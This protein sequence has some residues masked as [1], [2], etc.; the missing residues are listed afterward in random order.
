MHDFKNLSKK[1]SDI[2]GVRFDT[3]LAAYL[4][5]PSASSYA[6]DRI[7]AEYAPYEPEI[8]GE[9]DE[10]I[11]NACL[12]SLAC[13]TLENELEKTGQKK[14]F[15]EIEL[16]LARVL[17]EMELCGFS[18]DVN[19]LKALSSELDTR[20]KALESEIYSL[21]GYE[22]NLNSPKQLGAALFEKLGLPAKKKTKSGYS[23]GAEVLEGLKNEHPAVS[24]LLNYRQLAKLKSTYADGLQDCIA[25][26]GRI[27]STFNQTEAR[28]GRISSL[29]PNLQN[30]PVRTAE[31]RRLREYFNA[32]AGRVLCDADYSQ[33]ELRVLASMSGD[34]NMI[35][36]FGSG[37]DIHTV[38]A[39]QVFG[40]PQEMITPELR[41]RAK[42]VN[43]GI[44]YGIGAFSLS[45]DIGVTR[46]EA[47]KY[48]K[49]YLAA[50]PGVAAYM[51][52]AIEDAKK[53]GYVTT[54]YG[55]RRYI[56]ELSNSNG[57]M[58]AFGERVARNAPIQGTA[59]DII[60]IAMI[61]VSRSLKDEFPT[62]RLILQVHDEL[63]VECDERDAEGVCALLER[64]MES[65]ADLAVRLTAEAHFGKTWLEAKA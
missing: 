23:T 10:F 61:K 12:F 40:L 62:A 21:V 32:P 18:A 39:S 38:T 30:I 54:L 57:N 52:K 31:G 44:V 43:F 16:P 11:K 46:A 17:G 36:A 64:E 33:I 29:E 2:A 59:A 60:K 13:D 45:K 9:T 53:N 58:R 3:I 65:A 1:Y 37:T 28:T 5:N 26:D 41:S 49:S 4:C 51:E 48:I 14:L 56:P 19:G 63:I 25:E 55:R 7:I 8:E 22:F 35:N 24:L 42:A 15:D 6:T 20:I 50:Y 27:H 34:T 47:D